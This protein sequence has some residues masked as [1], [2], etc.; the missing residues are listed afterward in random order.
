MPS[1][2]EV[3]ERKK[4]KNEREQLEKRLEKQQIEDE[5]TASTLITSKSESESESS[6]SEG[7]HV[8]PITISSKQQTPPSCLKLENP[9]TM[10]MPRPFLTMDP[11]MPILQQT[12]H[13][14]PGPIS[15]SFGY[16]MPPAVNI[17]HSQYPG[18]QPMNYHLQ[19]GQMMH[20]GYQSFLPHSSMM[21]SPYNMMPNYVYPQQSLWG[22]PPYFPNMNH[23][24]QLKVGQTTPAVA[25]SDTTSERSEPNTT[26]T[27]ECEDEKEIEKNMRCKLTCVTTKT[28]C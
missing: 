5:P 9:K 25:A 14:P 12:T 2:E 27:D 21:L 3:I 19:P 10:P 13:M 20:P 18:M 22:V 16:N 6:P 17:S 23:P 24:S 11:S 4:L 1:I 7:L 8:I 15:Q 28:T 26:V